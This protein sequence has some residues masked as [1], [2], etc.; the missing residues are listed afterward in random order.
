MA[1]G[2]L[3][4]FYVSWLWHGCSETAIMA[5]P[6]NIT[7]MQYT[8]FVCASPEEEQVTLETCRGPLFSIN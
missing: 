6:T 3:R 7:R 5:R 2:I 4:V 8:K 1:L